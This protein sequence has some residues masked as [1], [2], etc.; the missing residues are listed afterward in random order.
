MFHDTIIS[1]SV[2]DSSEGASVL[3]PGIV[4]QAKYCL[5]DSTEVAIALVA[6]TL[7]P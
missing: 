6:Y 1:V 3:A 4:A 5:L 2:D 7:N